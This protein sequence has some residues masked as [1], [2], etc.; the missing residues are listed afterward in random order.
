[1]MAFETSSRFA[2]GLLRERV[3][4]VSVQGGS[5]PVKGLGAWRGG[6]RRSA[7]DLTT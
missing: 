1:M 2:D 3:M 6:F 5:A 7:P 4:G